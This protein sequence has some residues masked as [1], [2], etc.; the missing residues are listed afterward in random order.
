MAKNTEPKIEM[1]PVSNTLL[2]HI[3]DTAIIN[4]IDRTITFKIDKNSPFIDE[5]HSFM[6][7]KK[8]IINYIDIPGITKLRIGRIT[9][10]WEDSYKTVNFIY[11]NATSLK[12]FKRF[13]NDNE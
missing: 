7:H 8:D 12:N 3:L 10:D 9:N 4:T 6:M 1:L 11:P 13:E 5:I 2:Q